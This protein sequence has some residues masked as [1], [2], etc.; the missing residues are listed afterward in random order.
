MCVLFV[1]LN[2][3]VPSVLGRFKISV[4]VNIGL[5]KLYDLKKCSL[6]RSISIHFHSINM[7][8]YNSL[9]DVPDWLRTS[10]MEA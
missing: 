8:H 3:C 7:I 6:L 1:G 2:D 4:P 5:Q 9:W 10:N